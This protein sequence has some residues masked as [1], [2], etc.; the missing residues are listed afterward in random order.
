ME[1][2]KIFLLPLFLLGAFSVCNAQKGKLLKADQ[3]FN[4]GEFF[5]AADKY[6]DAYNDVSDKT[7]KAE[8]LFRIGECY[9][10]TSNPAKA[11]IWYAKAINKNYSNPLVYLYFAQA[12]LMNQK[13]DEAKEQFMKYKT[14]VP[15]DPRGGDGVLS[16]EFAQKMIN[17]PTG[18]LVENVKAINSKVSDYSPAFARDDYNELYFTSSRDEATGNNNHGATGQNFADI[19]VTRKDKKGKWSMP[20]PLTPNINTEAEEGTPSLTRNFSTMYY[21]SCNESKK[22]IMGCQIFSS[23][24]ENDDWTKGKPI[25][26]GDDSIV[27]AHPAISPDEL[28]LYF[29]SDMP[30]GSGGKDIWMC[31]R[32][33]VSDKWGK[34]VNLGDQINTPD[35]EEFPYVHPDG[36]LYFSSNGRVGMG[37]LDIYKAK[38][39]QDGNWKVENMGSPINSSADDFGITFQADEERGYFSS[40]RGVHGDDDIY[41]FVLPPLRF[42]ILGVVKDE[43]TDSIVPNATVKS[44]GSDGITVDTKTD[45]T[46]TFRFNLKPATDYVFIVSKTGFLNG[47]ERETTKG[48]DKSKDFKTII[49]ISSIAKPI[50]L[51]NIFYDFAKWDLRPE[52]M[53]ALDKL[54]ET[55]NDN[56]NITIELMSHTDSRGTDEDNLILS[57][58]RAQSVVDYLI[59]KGIAPDRL[60]AKGYGESQPMVVDK[61]TAAQYIFLPE[62]TLLDDKFVDKLPSSDLKEIAYQINRRT[63]FRVLSTNYKAKK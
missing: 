29:V 63:E 15:D 1:K 42:N 6:K 11:E 37:G 10:L 12:K 55:L 30:K 18:Y 60:S 62:G 7:K 50:E 21:S 61:R 25:E 20:V 4:A 52:S 39:D 53:V 58:K 57:Q 27:I 49:L 43:K 44:I 48:L 59:S 5:D 38:K 56:P 35:D 54:V 40:N 2:L 51:P 47:K 45:K 33:S 24:R 31:T 26:L 46:G 14:L 16:C 17:N 19:F 34:P 28:T 13:Y 41:S 23:T 9:R 32:A 22:R 3:I 8:I 36:T